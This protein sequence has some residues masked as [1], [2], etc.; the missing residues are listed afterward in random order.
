MIRTISQSYPSTLLDVRKFT[1]RELL[2][3]ER[4]GIIQED[5]RVELLGGQIVVMTIHPPHAATV[6]HLN[7]RFQRVLRIEYRLSPKIPY[8]FLMIWRTIT[9]RNQTS[10]W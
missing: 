1:Y 5:Q 8:G 2:E 7:R 4:I 3:M 10:C 9:S 6:S